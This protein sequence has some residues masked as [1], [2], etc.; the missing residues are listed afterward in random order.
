MACKNCRLITDRRPGNPFHRAQS[1][2]DTAEHLGRAWAAQRDI[3]RG[4]PGWVLVLGHLLAAEQHSHDWPGLHTMICEARKGWQ[5][6]PRIVPPW[7]DI[8][9]EL[10]RA[11]HVP[12]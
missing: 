8:E 2:S 5:A 7:A 11:G 10:G 4:H 12:Q 9:A 1:L 3:E 6:S